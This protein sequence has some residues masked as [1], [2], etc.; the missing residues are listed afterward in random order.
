[1]QWVLE[2]SKAEEDFKCGPFSGHHWI[3]THFGPTVISSGGSLVK[4]PG[5]TS[6]LVPPLIF[7]A[8]SLCHQG[9]KKSPTL[10]TINVTFSRKL[11]LA[12]SPSPRLVQMPLSASHCTPGMILELHSSYGTTIKYLYFFLLLDF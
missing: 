10:L 1:M 3:E 9:F 6:Q 11:R 8:D 4:A 12:L 7:L 2:N 5:E